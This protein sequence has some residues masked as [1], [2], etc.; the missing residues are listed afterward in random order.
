M[1]YRV[2]FRSIVVGL[3]SHQ[4]LLQT[5]GCLLLQ[6]SKNMVASERDIINS[7]LQADTP[8]PEDEEHDL[9][10]DAP[11]PGKKRVQ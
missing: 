6:G 3:L 7:S 5:I 11:L 4:I 10:Q 8:P 9:I 2:P 1:K